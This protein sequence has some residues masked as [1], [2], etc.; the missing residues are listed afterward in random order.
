MIGVSDIEKA[1]AFYKNVLGYD[2]IKYDTEGVFDDLGGFESG[3]NK[4]RRVLLQHSD[5]RRGPFSRILGP[6]S[7][8][9]IKVHGREPRKIF[10]DRYWGDLGFIHLCFDI[11][12]MN[13]LKENCIKNGH[14]FT[15]ESPSDFGMGE[16]AG[17]FTYVEDPDGTLIEFVETYKVPI[18]KKLGLYLNLKNRNPQKPLPNWIVK[19]LAFN[20]VKS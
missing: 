15:V 3:N 17:H 13:A 8:E 5:T 16:A 18:M 2:Q 10:K 9:L 6:S 1:I 20:R 11:T 7:I 4:F 19:S 14:P 12:G